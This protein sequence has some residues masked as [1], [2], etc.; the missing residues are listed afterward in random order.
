MQA[1]MSKFG[2][3]VTA[4]RTMTPL[5]GG[6]VKKGHFSRGVGRF[7]RRRLRRDTAAGAQMLYPALVLSM[8]I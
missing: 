8:R 6:Y 4:R 5:P 2:N 1:V 3:L 7:A